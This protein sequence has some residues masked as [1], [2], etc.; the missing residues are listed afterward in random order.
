MAD[1]QLAVAE[2]DESSRRAMACVQG[3]AG[4]TLMYISV[5]LI[6]LL[7]NSITG[8]DF[9]PQL[10]V[11]AAPWLVR[12]L[13]VLLD[14]GFIRF[15]LHFVEARRIAGNEQEQMLET[16]AA[17][18]EECSR[19]AMACVLGCLGVALV[20]VSIYQLLLLRRYHD[21]HHDDDD[22][23]FALQLPAVLA[24]GFAFGLGFHICLLFVAVVTD[25]YN[26]DPGRRRSVDVM[27]R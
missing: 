18:P 22:V 27:L 20:S 10:P 24:V 21:D 23:D 7:L 16:A 1:E 9:M 25:M 2:P 5:V 11:P 14:L 13:G 15:L 12:S 17:E 26:G 19:R 6:S 4:V 8:N 3:G